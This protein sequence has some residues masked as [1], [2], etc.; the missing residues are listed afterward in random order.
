MLNSK[1]ISFSNC[2]VARHHLT[3]GLKLN[4]KTKCRAKRRKRPNCDWLSED[5]ARRWRRR[6]LDERTGERVFLRQKPKRRRRSQ[7]ESLFDGRKFKLL[8]WWRELP[9]LPG[10]LFG[11][12]RFAETARMLAVEC[13]LNRLGEGATAKVAR[14][15]PGPCNGLKHGPMHA[16]RRKHGQDHQRIAK[17]SEHTANITTGC[18][19]T[20]KI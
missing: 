16:H 18:V 13:P 8:N 6:R 3:A 11:G 17:P 19:L 7:N 9:L 2:R 10:F 5:A 20:S 4:R 14:E 12:N 15:H 1:A